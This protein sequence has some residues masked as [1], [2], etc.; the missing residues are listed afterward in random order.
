M[1]EYRH[2]PIVNF[3]LA[4]LTQSRLDEGVKYRKDGEKS[5]GNNCPDFIW[6]DFKKTELYL[7]MNVDTLKVCRWVCEYIRRGR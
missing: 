4:I 7:N 1:E 3:W 5:R 6:R 2:D